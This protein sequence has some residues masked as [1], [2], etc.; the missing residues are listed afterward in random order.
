MLYYLIKP[1]T[2]KEEP[3]QHST[4][5]I[6][7][8]IG[9]TLTLVLVGNLF[10]SSV[11][12]ADPANTRVTQAEVEQKRQAY[13]KTKRQV[14][15]LQ[16]KIDET[17]QQLSQTFME[18]ERLNDRQA[19]T[20]KQLNQLLVDFYT[21]GH[22]QME[23]QLLNAKTVSEFLFRLELLRLTIERNIKLFQKYK[24]QK[25][26]IEEKKKELQ[27]TLKKLQPLLQQSEQK[28]KQLQ[29]QYKT[30]SA[31]LKAREQEKQLEEPATNDL[32]WLNKARAMIGTVKYVFGAASYPYFDCSSWTQYVFRTYRNIELPRTAAAQSKV[33]TFVSKENLQPGDLVF[34]QGTYKAGV[35]HVGIYLGNGQF[36]S[37]KNSRLH[38]Q[39][40]SI[41][42]AYSK[43][44]YWGAKRVNR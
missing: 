19:Q 41:N 24:K 36:I 40:E 22:Y 11:S 29:Q 3:E 18:I 38:L 16:K 12:F 42:S 6:I 35:S 44:H 34:F 4:M 43:R 27:E 23:R 21:S 8:R 7:H 1:R 31:Q 10:F 14:E 25:V 20:Q 15:Q 17:D 37:N 2:I 32:S 5:N 39:I 9:I 33:G 13:E 26:L 28:S 30:L